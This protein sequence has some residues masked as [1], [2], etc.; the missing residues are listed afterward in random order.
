M[1]S[2]I[3][4]YYAPQGMKL[5]RGDMGTKTIAIWCLHMLNFHAGGASAVVAST[6]AIA[7][8]RLP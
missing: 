7:Q 8:L 6:L 5:M 1:K 4:G 2:L 3:F